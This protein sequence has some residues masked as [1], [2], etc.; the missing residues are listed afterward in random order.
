M[1]RGCPIGRESPSTKARDSSEP[2]RIPE[3]M[4][5]VPQPDS[6]IQID[7]YLNSKTNANHGWHEG[8]EVSID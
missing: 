2:L 8:L 7:H 1:T 4:V 5:R 3:Q 6:R